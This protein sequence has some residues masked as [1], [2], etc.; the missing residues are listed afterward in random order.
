MGERI[1]NKYINLNR[2]EFVIT[3][4]CT[5]SCKHCSV[6]DV[7]SND[8]INN[9]AAINIINDLSKTYTIN[10]IMTFGGEPLLYSDTVCQIHT[11]AYKSNIN[12]RSIIT[13]GYFS[14]N[15]KNIEKTAENICQSNVTD[16]LL[17]VDS[18]HQE[19]IP[20]EPVKYFAESLIRYGIHKLRTHPAWLIDKKNMNPYNRE[21]VKI[22]DDFKAIGIEPSE[23]NIIFP[24]GNA[25][26]YLKDYFPPV[27]EKNIFVP[28]GSLPY[29]G[30][31]DEINCLGINPN[32]DVVA[33]SV[34]IGNVY[35]DNII[36]II[37]SYDPYTNIYTKML[38]EGGIKKLYEYVMGQGMNIDKSDC[39]T[40]CMLCKK[41]MKK[42]NE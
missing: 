12:N 37:K 16:I 36:E 40:S 39:Y 34:V 25:I 20:L 26:K 41:I 7:D 33:C 4:N 22:I 19:K 15:K 42:I 23:G 29:T 28:C 1:M 27:D 38:V 31:I 5:G 17:S 6:A 8:H 24:A 14:K 21:T 18:F 10:S 35:K 11:M 13:N 3:T 2:I 32:G 30:R 9:G